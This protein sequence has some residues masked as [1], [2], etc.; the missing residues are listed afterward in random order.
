[1]SPLRLRS[2]LSFAPRKWPCR[3]NP[4]IGFLAA[5]GRPGGLDAV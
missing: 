5:P 4:A 1:V 2:D 3:I